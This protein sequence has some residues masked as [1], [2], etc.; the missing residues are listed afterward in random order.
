[1]C[2]KSL[3]CINDGLYVELGVIK[4]A[5]KKH[6]KKGKR[7]NA[8]LSSVEKGINK[9]MSLF[10]SGKNVTFLDEKMSDIDSA[11][12][13]STAKDED[14]KVSPSNKNILLPDTVVTPSESSTNIDQLIHQLRSEKV[15][16]QKKRKTV[17]TSFQS[18]LESQFAYKAKKRAHPQ[19]NKNIRLKFSSMVVSSIPP[20]R[21][22]SSLEG[23]NR[24]IKLDM[25]IDRS[26]KLHSSM[27]NRSRVSN[28]PLIVRPKISGHDLAAKL[29]RDRG[30]KV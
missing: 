25:D 17:D 24:D 14:D 18:Y 16:S 11:S 7:R 2:R 26:N 15:Q 21:L 13:I 19:T 9:P 28:K 22:N 20:V 23:R 1:M 27:D 6:S 12:S 5:N 30:N 4:K 29:F 8:V 3:K 10:F